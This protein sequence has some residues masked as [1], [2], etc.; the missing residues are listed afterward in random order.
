ML[1]ATCPVRA[2]AAR[3]MHMC[4]PIYMYDRVYIYVSHACLT[5]WLLLAECLTQ[6]NC[7]SPGGAGPGRRPAPAWLKVGTSKAR[8][9]RRA[10]APYCLGGP[11]SAGCEV[12]CVSASPGRFPPSCFLPLP[13]T[14]LLAQPGVGPPNPLTPP[15]I[16]GGSA[17]RDSH[18][19]AGETT[20]PPSPPRLGWSRRGGGIPA[21][22]PPGGP[23]CSLALVLLISSSLPVPVW[24]ATVE[25][26]C[27]YANCCVS[28]T[29]PTNA[30]DHMCKC[31]M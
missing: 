27:L 24:N 30:V 8:P 25:G 10:G 4:C 5:V 20:Y 7:A 19:R 14:P 12:G 31:P 1:P 6:A 17:T 2:P 16:P 26:H 29:H 3:S 22:G 21:T 9:L 23:L 13:P 15:P 18:R 28:C 11:G